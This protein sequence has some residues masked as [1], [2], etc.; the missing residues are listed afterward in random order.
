MSGTW[1]RPE[2]APRPWWG[3]S[4]QDITPEIDLGDGWGRT[5]MPFPVGCPVRVTDAQQLALA[6]TCPDAIRWFDTRRGE[7]P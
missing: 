7:R 5:A 4:D 1:D 6:E 3:V 2:D